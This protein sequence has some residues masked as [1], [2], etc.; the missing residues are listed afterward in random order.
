MTAG[1]KHEDFTNWRR[2]YAQS[3]GH[4]PCE[5]GMMPLHMPTYGA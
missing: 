3:L 2:D 4:V 5:S 1:L